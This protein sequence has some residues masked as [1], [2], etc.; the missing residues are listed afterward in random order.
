VNSS[1]S[2]LGSGLRLT[3]RRRGSHY[4]KGVSGISLANGAVSTRIAFQRSRRP[5]KKTRPSPHCELK[6]LLSNCLM[7]ERYANA[8]SGSVRKSRFG[9][10]HDVVKLNLQRA[11]YTLNL[12]STRPPSQFC[13]RI[14][15]WTTM[16]YLSVGHV[17]S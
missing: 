6:V 2:I 11:G 8:S 10:R 3:L 1:D 12:L 9:A 13:H 5:F 14:C 4:A 17:S 7:I 16:P 15:I